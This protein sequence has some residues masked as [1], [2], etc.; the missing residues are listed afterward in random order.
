MRKNGYKSA[1]RC[2]GRVLFDSEKAQGRNGNCGIFYRVDASG[3]NVCI[4]FQLFFL[5]RRRSLSYSLWI[6]HL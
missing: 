5:T 4:I 1:V 2:D 6:I 3:T